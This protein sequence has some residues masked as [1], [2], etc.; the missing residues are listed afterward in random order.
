MKRRVKLNVLHKD[1]KEIGA[2]KA[3]LEIF[4]VQCTVKDNEQTTVTKY[5]QK[6]NQKNDVRTMAL[7]V[8]CKD[9]DSI[10]VREVLS[11]SADYLLSRL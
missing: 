1:P 10:P 7:S 9:N 4:N 6:A 8:K 3:W 2:S 11:L 5:A